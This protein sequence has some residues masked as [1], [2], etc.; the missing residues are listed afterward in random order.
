ME[1]TE[2]IMEIK[3]DGKMN[4]DSLLATLSKAIEDDKDSKCVY[5]D[6]YKKAYG[7]RLSE[8]L[9][10]N[11][12]QKMCITD[13]STDRTTGEKWT[14]DQT[15]EIGNRIGVKWDRISKWEFYA[16]MNAFY[17]D[18]YRTA[19]KYELHDEPEF[20]GDMVWDYFNDEDA[21]DKTPFTYYFSFVSA[22]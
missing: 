10:K 11:W 8:G 17:S 19:K 5:R 3:R 20:F 9:I 16:F 15:T 21:V 2:L 7:E 12:V 22:E 4:T 18:F 6:V 1:L 13:G 14:V